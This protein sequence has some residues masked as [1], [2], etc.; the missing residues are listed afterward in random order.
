ME[1]LIV[2]HTGRS[3]FVRLLSVCWCIQLPTL[4]EQQG[5]VSFGWL[6]FLVT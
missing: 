4:T 5:R 3:G 1:R 2:D 6:V